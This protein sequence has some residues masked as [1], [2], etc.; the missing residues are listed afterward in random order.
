M[1][2]PVTRALIVASS[3]LLCAT[4]TLS[5]QDPFTPPSPKSCGPG[6]TNR[7]LRTLGGATIGGWVGFVAAKIRLSDWND[8]AHGSAATRQRNQS[9]AI[10]A[11]LGAVVGNV[12]FRSRSCTA[13]SLDKTEELRTRYANRPITMEE[14]QQSGVNGTVYDLVYTLRRT[15]LNTRGVETLREGPRAVEIGNGNSVI[16]PGEPQL[17]VYLDNM[18][19][20]A[21]S[22]LRDLPVAGVIGVRYYTGSEAT[23]K[24]GAGHSHGAIQVLTVIDP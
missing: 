22:Q 16:V 10:G 1:R 13:P 12:P 19:M 24:W 20:G 7:A 14:I 9:I 3:L 2:P 17:M 11:V 8:N 18:R 21:L 4:A 23:Y 5:A 6:I 15:W